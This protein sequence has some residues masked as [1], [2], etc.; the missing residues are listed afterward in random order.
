MGNVQTLSSGEVMK[1][2]Y[3]VGDLLIEDMVKNDIEE[4][5]GF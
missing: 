1:T 5:E 4:Y 3:Q 2:K